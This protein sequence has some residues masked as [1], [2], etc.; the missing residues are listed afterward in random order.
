[1]RNIMKSSPMQVRD[2]CQA[3][4][5]HVNRGSYTLIKTNSFRG[6]GWMA[7]VIENTTEAIFLDC[8]QK[9]NI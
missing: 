5:G 9:I 7:K 2:S 8:K 3:L 6:N 1:M 4:L